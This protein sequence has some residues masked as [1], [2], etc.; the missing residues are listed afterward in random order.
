MSILEN[1]GLRLKDLGKKHNANGLTVYAEDL[2]TCIKQ[3][4]LTKLENELKRF[5]SIIERLKA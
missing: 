5:P 2:L 4:D 3:F 1:F